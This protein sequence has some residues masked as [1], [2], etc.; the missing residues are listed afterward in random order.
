MNFLLLGWSTV[1]ANAPLR[2][3]VCLCYTGI[4]NLYDSI[5]ASRPTNALKLNSAGTAF[6]DALNRGTSVIGTQLLDGSIVTGN[7]RSLQVQNSNIVSFIDGVYTSA[8]RPFTLEA[9]V[10]PLYF[11]T[12]KMGILS[13]GSSEYDGIW[14]DQDYINFTVKFATD[15]ATVRWPIPD[16][17]ATYHVVGTYDSSKIT[18]SID[19]QA[20]ASTSV[21]DYSAQGFKTFSNNRLHGGQSAQAEQKALVDG[22][23]VYNRVISDAEIYNHFKAGRRVMSVA[24]I[25]TAFG[26]NMFDGTVRD[27]YPSKTWSTVDEWSVSSYSDVQFASGVL[28][29]AVNDATGLSK[30]GVWKGVYETSAADTLNGLIIDWESDGNF[31]VAASLDNEA[32]WTNVSNGRYVPG[33]LNWTT[34]GNNVTIRVTF[35]GGVVNDPSVIRSITARAYLTD[36]VYGLFNTRYIDVSTNSTAE[37]HSHPIEGRADAGFITSSSNPMYLQPDVDTGTP[38]AINT[39]ELWFKYDVQESHYVIDGRPGGG[40]V[41]VWINGTGQFSFAGLTALYINGTQQL[42]GQFTPVPGVWYHIVI[43]LAAPNSNRIDFPASAKT[44]SVI[45]TYP[46]AL[47]AAQVSAI[48]MMYTDFP[49]AALA[50]DTATVTEPANAFKLYGYDWSIAPAG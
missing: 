3:G 39:V 29:P 6:V 13:H 19:G 35:T 8:N 7:A 48:Y 44:Y 2:R 40:T 41:Y 12:S 9:W 26:G 31:T 16:H 5:L 21:E 49:N 30:P 36:N 10:R 4:M 24:D 46:T 38:Q 42:T 34:G 18:L 14:I 17:P 33:T 22:I 11:Q 47:T 20:V 23:A 45:N 50:T 32:T 25:V 43:V 15:S 1:T 28:A 27:P 37:K